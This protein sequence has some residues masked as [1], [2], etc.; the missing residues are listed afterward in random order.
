MRRRT[1]LLRVALV[2]ALTA[3]GLGTASPA[4]ANVAH[5]DVRV[6]GL[7]CPF[8]AYGL[9]KKLEALP[10][11]GRVEVDLETG[12]ASFDVAS[13]TSLMPAAVEGAVREAGF[14]PRDITVR[15]LG[16]VRGEGDELR[17]EVGGGR[18]L[19]LRGGEALGR[20]R[21]LVEAGHRTLVV[22]GAASAAA[23]GG[24]AWQVRVDRVATGPAGP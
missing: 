7:A 23:E 22:T 11:V 19:R 17:L 12:R 4:A 20:L 6:D 15:A 14:S 9:E 2:A 21:E 18:A 13:E 5:Y 1:R 3:G 10:G 8:C 16:T 24:T